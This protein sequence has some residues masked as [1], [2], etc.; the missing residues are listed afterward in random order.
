[1]PQSR[2]AVLRTCADAPDVGQT[3]ANL[4][5]AALSATKATSVAV[6]G[7]NVASGASAA[8]Q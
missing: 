3:G 4:G 1:M 7:A 5:Q 6:Q 8:K 2:I